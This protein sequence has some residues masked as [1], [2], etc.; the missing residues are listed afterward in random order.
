MNLAIVGGGE[1]F[2]ASDTFHL[3]RASRVSYLLADLCHHGSP[4]LCGQIL[5]GIKQKYFTFK[6]NLYLSKTFLHILSFSVRRYKPHDH[7]P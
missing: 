3:Q 1:C 5:Q 7:K 6:Y 2:S 4:A